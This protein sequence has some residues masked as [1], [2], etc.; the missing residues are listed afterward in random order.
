MLILIGPTSK[1]CYIYFYAKLPFAI[2][3]WIVKRIYSILKRCNCKCVN[4][5]RGTD[6]DS[7]SESEIDLYDDSK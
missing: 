4:K 2:L 7:E 1:I 6:S 3:M 5:Q